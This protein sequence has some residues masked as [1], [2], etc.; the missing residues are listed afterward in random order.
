MLQAR[1]WGFDASYIY[2]WAI[3]PGPLGPSSHCRRPLS[4]VCLSWKGWIQLARFSMARSDSCPYRR[5]FAEYFADCPGYEPELFT[6]TTMRG[7]SLAPIWTCGHLTAGQVNEQP[8]H[9]YARC[10]LGDAIGRRDA[11]FRKLRGSRAA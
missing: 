2:V 9:W 5:P 10:L 1:H 11:L 6:P 7:A 3:F 4:E 8:G